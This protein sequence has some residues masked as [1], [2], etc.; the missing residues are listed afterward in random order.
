RD[1]G[2]GTAQPRRLPEGPGQ[3]RAGRAPPPAAGRRADAGGDCRGGKDL[4]GRAEPLA[5]RAV[6]AAD[7]AAAAGGPPAPG[8]LSAPAGRDRPDAQGRREGA[9]HGTD[10]HPAVGGPGG[11]PQG[12]RGDRL[13][14]SGADTEREMKASWEL[15][16]ASFLNLPIPAD[17]NRQVRK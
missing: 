5:A 16:A 12:P 15:V 10:G 8:P 1:G 9:K 14:V 3:A 6:L 13:P 17:P 11:H 7:P 2:A 4:A